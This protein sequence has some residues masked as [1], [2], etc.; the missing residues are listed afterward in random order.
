MRQSK[1]ELESAKSQ[2]AELIAAN[3]L[4]Y[5]KRLDISAAFKKTMVRA[6]KYLI[7]IY[8]LFAFSRFSNYILM[9]Y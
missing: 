7:K 9:Y 6:V 8:Y 3:S 5:R 1:T 4:L 2:L